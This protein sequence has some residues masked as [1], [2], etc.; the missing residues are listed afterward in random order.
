[1]RVTGCPSKVRVYNPQQKRLNPRTNSGYFIRY[2]KRSKEYKFY[3]PSHGI[4][5]VESRNVKFL[6]NDLIIRSDQIQI[7]VSKNN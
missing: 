2:T 3:F 5:I 4:R 1:M 6:K 7:L